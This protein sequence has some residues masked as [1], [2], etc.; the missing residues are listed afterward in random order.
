MSIIG[1]PNTDE[2]EETLIFVGR[3]FKRVNIFMLLNIMYYQII[4]IFQSLFN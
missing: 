3:L 4:I 1:E 2:F